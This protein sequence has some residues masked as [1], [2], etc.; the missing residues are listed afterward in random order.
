MLSRVVFRLYA[1]NGNELAVRVDAVDVRAG[2][3]AVKITLIKADLQVA[4]LLAD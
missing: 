1:A 4:Q 2:V 3:K